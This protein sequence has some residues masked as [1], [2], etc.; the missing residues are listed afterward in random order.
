MT[1]RPPNHG[2]FLL[3]LAPLAG[4]F[5][6]PY[7]LAQPRP[8]PSKAPLQCERVSFE[9]AF[10]D[11]PP[12]DI[13]CA[14]AGPCPYRLI[15]QHHWQQFADFV[16]MC[17]D[18]RLLS[19]AEAVIRSVVSRPTQRSFV[20]LVAVYVLDPNLRPLAAPFIH[21][22]NG[23]AEIVRNYFGDVFIALN[24][25]FPSHMRSPLVPR[26]YVCLSRFLIARVS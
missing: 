2:R 6:G 22:E 11:H 15:W 24:F 25:D 23:V 20:Y 9:L 17:L 14:G 19:F 21:F 7:G 3:H 12:A 10:L 13:R 5:F 1:L 8:L 4:L 26:V 18:G 16:R